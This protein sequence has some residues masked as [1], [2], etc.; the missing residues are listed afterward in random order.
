MPVSKVSFGVAHSGLG[1]LSEILA[2]R[3]GASF[4]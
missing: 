1:L 2:D 4:L 3:Q